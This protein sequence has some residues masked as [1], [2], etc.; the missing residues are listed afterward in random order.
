MPKPKHKGPGGR[1]PGAGRP[2]KD[3]AERSRTVCLSLSAAEAA[4]CERLGGTV[5]E[6]IRTLIRRDQGTSG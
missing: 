6:G 2:P 1:R 5:Q 4:H 3:P